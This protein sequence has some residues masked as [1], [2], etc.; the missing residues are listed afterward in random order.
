MIPLRIGYSICGFVTGLILLFNFLVSLPDGKLH[1]VFCDV[2][3]GDAVY[4]RLPDGRDMLIDGGPNEKVI[5]CLSRHMAFWDR[6]IDLMFLTHAEHDHLGGLMAV[7]SRFAVGSV[8]LSAVPDTSEQ[9]LQLI[10]ALDGNK[11]PQKHL[12]AGDSLT[13][14]NVEV[15]VLWPSEAVISSLRDYA[16]ADASVVLGVST[17][18]R[19]DLSLVLRLRYG[20][21]D[22]LF[23]GDAGIGAEAEYRETV[24]ADGGI[25]VLKMPHHGSKTGMT[26]DYFDALHLGLAVISVG[27]NTYGHPATEIL[28]MLAK[29]NVRVLRTDQEGDIEIIS[30]GIDW[31]VQTSKS[32]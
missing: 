21:F 31:T 8:V 3:Q 7:V 11:V 30:D 20:M 10:S 23:P 26:E 29:K 9:Y 1:I 14:G 4:I 17:P 27:R 12:T 28:D 6:K 13:A 5:A 2:G 19:N 32:F 25:E 18:D 24:L 16:G 15:H 22:I